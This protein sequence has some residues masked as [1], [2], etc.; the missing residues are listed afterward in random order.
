MHG[1]GQ[2]HLEEDHVTR[3]SPRDAPLNTENRRNSPSPN[4]SG[5]AAL[6]GRFFYRLPG[7]LFVAAGRKGPERYATCAF[8]NPQQAAKCLP[9]WFVYASGPRLLAYPGTAAAGFL[10]DVWKQRRLQGG[11]PASP[12]HKNRGTVLPRF[13]APQ[14][15]RFSPVQSTLSENCSSSSS[16]SLAWPESSSLVAALSSAVAELVCTTVEI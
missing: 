7:N 15:L 10:L 3:A 12:Q 8:P 2:Q 11:R 13:P 6:S 1:C 16:S 4:S 14:V 5:D 9:D